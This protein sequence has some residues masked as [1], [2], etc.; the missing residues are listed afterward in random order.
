MDASGLE[1]IANYWGVDAATLAAAL[2]ESNPREEIIIRSA[3][4]SPSEHILDDEE[5]ETWDD[6]FTAHGMHQE[7]PASESNVVERMEEE[8]LDLTHATNRAE[9][10]FEDL[11]NGEYV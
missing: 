10:I 8:L 9:K 11:A 4:Q 6:G 5:E 3:S 7:A 1:P 2:N